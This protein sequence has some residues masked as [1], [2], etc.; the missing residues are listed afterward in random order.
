MNIRSLIL[1]FAAASF[2]ILVGEAAPA[3]AAPGFEATPEAGA[4][5][6]QEKRRWRRNGTYVR[7][8]LA[9]VDSRRET[10]VAAPFARVYNGRW[11]TWVRAPFVNLWAPR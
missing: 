3:S 7:A 5:L 9:E 4:A 11:G 8:P 1:A 6:V 10:W 2:A